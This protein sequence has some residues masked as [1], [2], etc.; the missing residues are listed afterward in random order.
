MIYEKM[1]PL[2]TLILVFA[3]C[4][5]TTGISLPVLPHNP[6]NECWK[7]LENF[8]YSYNTLD[9]PLLTATL[10]QEFQWVLAEK[11]WDD[12]NG[13]G[14]IDSSFTRDMYLSFSSDLFAD[15]ETVELTLDGSGEEVWSGDTTGQTVVCV[16][17][18][19]LKVEYPGKARTISYG[20]WSILVRPDSTDDWNLF[21][22]TDIT[23]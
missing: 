6:V 4:G 8:E 23:E 1:I 2:L 9:I 22:V 14:I 10:D 19:T 5:D 17:S 21:R 18:F 3:S 12:Y 16:R 15:A 11:D 20:E 7:A 13:D